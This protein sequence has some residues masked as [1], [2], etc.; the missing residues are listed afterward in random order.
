M[1]GNIKENPIRGE[2]LQ[3]RITDEKKPICQHRF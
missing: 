3:C 2:R 1:I